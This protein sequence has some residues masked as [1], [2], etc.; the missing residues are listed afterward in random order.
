MTRPLA[1]GGG[2]GLPCEVWL[3][4]TLLTTETGSPEDQTGCQGP[5][6]TVLSPPYYLHLNNG[7]NRWFN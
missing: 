5:M 6:K 4:F 2:S 7:L 3:V 1:C